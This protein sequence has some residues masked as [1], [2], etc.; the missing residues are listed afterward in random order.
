MRTPRPDGGCHQ[1]WTSPS[2]NWRAA[3]RSRC[4]RS[5][6]RLGVDQRHR[7]LQLVAEAE[8]AAGLVEAAARPQAAGQRLVEQP[9]VGQHVER[10]VGRLDLDRA[11][12]AA[13]SIARPPRA[14][15]ARA[16]GAA[17]ALHQLV[18]VVGARCRHAEQED[19][20][21]LLPSASSKRHLDRRAGIQS[22]RRPCRTGARCAH[23]PPDCASV[24]LRP[25]NSVRSP[26]TV[27]SVSLDVEEG[28][29]VGELGV[30][31]VAGEERAACRI[32][33]GDHVHGRFGR[34]SPSTHST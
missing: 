26:V 29:A 33:L 21:A 4:S 19:D 5:S 28:D 20:L 11:E 7:V 12:R 10:R 13:S 27:R 24:P 34:R 1:C 32:D 9:A 6:A 8:R 16:V 25:R 23:A 3:Q 17:E 30:V 18:G 31:G 2:R 14:H 15:R 22:R